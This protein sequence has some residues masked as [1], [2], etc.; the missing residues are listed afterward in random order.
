VP[1]LRNADAEFAKASI[2]INQMEVGNALSQKLSPAINDFGGNTRLNANAF[3]TA[4]RGGDSVAS[5]VTGWK[6]ASLE[7][8]MSPSQMATLRAVAQQLARRANADDLGRAVGSNTAQNLISQNMLRQM[9]GP[10]GLPQGWAEKGAQSSLL[11]TV[12]APVQWAGQIGQG[13]IM[14]RLAQA[15]LDPNDAAGLLTR[16]A[17]QQL[18]GWWVK[19][20]ALL[21][22]PALSYAAQ[23]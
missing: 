22:L 12:T 1:A 8:T 14:G 11:Q 13:R 20:Q 9:L 7:D 23:Q 5:K 18:P 17:Q 19:N 16:G 2:P 10:L 21:T 3:A 15:A 6:G 4:L